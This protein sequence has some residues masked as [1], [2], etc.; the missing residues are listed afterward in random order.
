V[1]CQMPRVLPPHLPSMASYTPDTDHWVY[2]L[3]FFGNTKPDTGPT[4]REAVQLQR[5]MLNSR[6]TRSPRAA[7]KASNNVGFLY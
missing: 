2:I 6:G 4:A 7:F 5:A 3:L 1:V